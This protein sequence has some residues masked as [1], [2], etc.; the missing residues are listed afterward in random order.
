M[1]PLVARHL[2]QLLEKEGLI[3]RDDSIQGLRFY[4]S[5]HLH[6][7]RR[8]HHHHHQQQEE[9]EEEQQQ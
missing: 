8:H 3:C 6:F 5:R 1:P 2:F 4:N 7:H 9:T